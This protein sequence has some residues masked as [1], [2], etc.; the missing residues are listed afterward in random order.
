MPGRPWLSLI[1]LIGTALTSQPSAHAFQESE[2]RPATQGQAVQGTIRFDLY[3]GYLIVAHGSVGPFKNLNF[4]V[5]T[6]ATST[7]VDPRVA[8]KLHLRLTP[9]NVVVLDGKVNGWEAAV[10]D[11]QIGPVHK[12]G[13]RGIVEDLSF[14]EKSLPLRID[15]I[16]G[17]DVLAQSPFL[18]DY[19]AHTIH[20][21][22][23]PRLQTSLPLQ[24]DGNLATVEVQVNHTP[25]RFLL[26]TGASA[27]VLFESAFSEAALPVPVSALRV[28]A[29][30]RPNS[31][32]DFDRRPISLRSLS[33]GGTDFGRETGYVAHNRRQAGLDFDGLINPVN[34]GIT[35]L[36]ID[37]QQGALTFSR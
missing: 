19:A 5:D 23:L 2:A 35:R 31:I 1:V 9:A 37:V 8:Q 17:L 13:L 27:L 36:A 34:L 25:V 6:G 14:L 21:G 22:T 32:G 28:D 20:F 12:S 16:I 15:A 24:S 11:V 30:K 33:L 10:P 4:L 3:Q 7:V 29:V 26:D 18:I